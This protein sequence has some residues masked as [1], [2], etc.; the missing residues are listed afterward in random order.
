MPKFLG[1]TKHHCSKPQL[2]ENLTMSAFLLINDGP[3]LS[4]KA[5]FVQKKN[6]LYRQSKMVN[7]FLLRENGINNIILKM[8]FA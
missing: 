1:G 5:I 7:S 2:I 6:K 3:K 4:L 8:D